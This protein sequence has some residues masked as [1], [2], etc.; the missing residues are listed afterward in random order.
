MTFAHQVK[1]EVCHNKAFTGRY[2]R[3]FLYGMLLFGKTFGK[4]S[5]SLSTEHKA[6]ARLYA[7]MLFSQ[8]PMAASVTTREYTG[9]FEKSTYIVTVDDENDRQIILNYFSEQK[10]GPLFASQE[11]IYAFLAGALLACANITDPKKDYHFEFCAPK[12]EIANQLLHLLEHLDLSAR[13][14]V[15]RGQTLVYIKESQSIENLLTMVGAHKA[16]ME[17]MNVK[18][19][20]DMRNQVN[21]VTNCETSNIVKSMGTATVQIADIHFLQEKGRLE[22]LPIPLKEAAAARLE[23]PE[24][25]L[26]ELAEVLGISRSGI[27]HRLRKISDIAKEVR[28]EKL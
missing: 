2:Q 23:N 12:P 6:V 7:R 26:R 3:P 17:M 14:T 24:A 18:I 16:V 21:R 4:D 8:V 5:I 1:N 28:S 13:Q 22:G 11:H 27:N 10:N 20:K 19:Y 25:S 9:S 15:R